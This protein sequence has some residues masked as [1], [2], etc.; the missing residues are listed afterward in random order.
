MLQYLQY[1]NTY[2][3]KHYLMVAYSQQ[4]LQQPDDVYR[5]VE[6]TD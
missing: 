5:L 1:E 3:N 2:H 4:S 6:T